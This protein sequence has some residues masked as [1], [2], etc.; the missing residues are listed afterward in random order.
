MRPASMAPDEVSTVTDRSRL[1]PNGMP[2]P[3]LIWCRASGSGERISSAVEASSMPVANGLGAAGLPVSG[4][5]L[6]GLGE[7]V[8]LAGGTLVSGPNAGEFVVEA[9]LPWPV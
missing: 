5:G 7:R 1:T 4:I 9:M 3:L 8:A 2:A 6:V